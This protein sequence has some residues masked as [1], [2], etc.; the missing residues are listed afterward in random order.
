MAL[1]EL[2]T[3]AIEAMIER[4]FMLTPKQIVAI[5]DAG[6]SRGSDEATA[7][8]WGSRPDRD[9]LNELEAALVWHDDCGLT[10]EM[11][12]DQKLV[13]WAAFKAAAERNT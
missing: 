8:D 5:Y 12:Y 13:W 9:K 4:K 10:T 1:G 7:Y 3:K 6:R 11:D 2:E